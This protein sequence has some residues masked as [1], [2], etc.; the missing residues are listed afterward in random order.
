MTKALAKSAEAKLAYHQ[1][2]MVACERAF[3][4]H[5]YECGLLL[6]EQKKRLSHG[7]WEPWLKENWRQSERT[8]RDYMR[9]AGEL[10]RKSVIDCETITEAKKL[11]PPVKVKS[12]TLA[13]LNEESPVNQP[14]LE[15][16]STESLSEPIE[17]ETVEPV[18]E[19]VYEDVEEEIPVDKQ[20]SK[21]RSV[22]KQHNNAMVRAIDELHQL[23]PSKTRHGELLVHFRKIDELVGGWK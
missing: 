22:I 21:L 12:A 16:S 17:N 7:E 6:N 4:E 18:A 10:Q 1:D 14:F 8:A 20:A 11:L 13:V 5:A 2:Q 19:E 23:K 15:Q 9:I 3:V